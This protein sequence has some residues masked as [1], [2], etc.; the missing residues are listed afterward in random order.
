L[1]WKV[2]EQRRGTDRLLML[3]LLVLW[4]YKRAKQT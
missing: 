3:D 4:N 2:I 1:S